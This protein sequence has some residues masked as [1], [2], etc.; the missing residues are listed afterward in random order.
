MIIYE[1]MTDITTGGLVVP[2]GWNALILE[3]QS[4]RESTS[5]CKT[6]GQSTGRDPAEVLYFEAIRS[7][8]YTV[9]EARA[10]CREIPQLRFSFGHKHGLRSNIAHYVRQYARTYPD[11]VDKT[12]KNSY[13]ARGFDP[14][15]MQQF[16]LPELGRGIRAEG[17]DAALADMAAKA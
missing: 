14:Y 8:G 2:G 7:A 13:V 15:V 3:V 10:W 4:V 9:E 12:A 5:T 11:L 6:C 17:I 16:Y 1:E